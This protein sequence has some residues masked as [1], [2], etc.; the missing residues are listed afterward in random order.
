MYQES[1]TRIGKGNMETRFCNHLQKMVYS[2]QKIC[3]DDGFEP[4]KFFW[5]DNSDQRLDLA[6]CPAR[7]NRGVEDCSKCRQKKDILE[8][9]KI[10][11][12]RARAN[13]ENIPH[14][15]KKNKH[16]ETQKHIEEAEE[17]AERE[18]VPVIVSEQKPKITLHRKIKEEV[19]AP[20]KLIKKK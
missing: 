18:N 1:P 15:I 2:T 14:I 6:V 7:Q 11:G 9:R 3:E 17:D 4:H 16:E 20:K 5:C 13:R 10:M 8:I 12:L 19:P